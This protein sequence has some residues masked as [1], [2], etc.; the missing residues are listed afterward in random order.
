LGV[1]GLLRRRLL[2]G[3][4]VAF[5]TLSAAMVV[6]GLPMALSH[7][8]AKM[9]RTG[10]M[11]VSGALLWAYRDKIVMDRRL[12]VLCM[13]L[14]TVGSFS[15]NYRLIAAP[16]VAYLM[17]YAALAWGRHRRLVLNNDVS[18]GTYVYAFPIQQTCL[19][20]GVPTA[21]FTFT[22]ISM[23]LTLPL[24]ATSWFV[25]ERPAMRGRWPSLR[26][27]VVRPAAPLPLP[28]RSDAPFLER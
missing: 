23:A 5:W 13:A 8:L 27:R 3:L 24:A 10:L 26:P 17:L 15:P 25:I 28:A 6:A 20:V 9:P 7:P 16:A 19:M 11:F 22:V 12:A 2:V 4:G 14:V 21:W 18:Y 1:L